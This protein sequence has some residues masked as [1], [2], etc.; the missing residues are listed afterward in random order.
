MRIRIG[1]MGYLYYHTKEHSDCDAEAAKKHVI[2]KISDA[3]KILNREPL[4]SN[5]FS[6][7]IKRASLN[8]ARMVPLM[9]DY[10]DN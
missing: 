4:S 5:P 10:D 6:S 7:T 8:L 1:E 3:W 9:S 2:N